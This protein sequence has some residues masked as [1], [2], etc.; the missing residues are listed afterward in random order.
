M[1]ALLWAQDKN[2]LIGKNNTLPWRLPADLK[3]FKETTLGHPIVMGRKTYE[4]IGKPLPGRTNIILTTNEQYEAKE[5]LIFHSKEAILDWIEAEK[6]DVFI[7]GGSEI[8][9]LFM[10]EAD[11]LYVT[12]IDEAFEGDAHFPTVNWEEWTLVKTTNGITDEKNKYDHEF[13]VY[14]RK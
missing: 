1:I 10:N 9:Q 11:H 14:N 8:Y 12:K 4:S 3:Y 5:C 2:G 6:K 7:T 13:Q